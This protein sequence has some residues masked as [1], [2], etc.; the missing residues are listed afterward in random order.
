M[1]EHKFQWQGEEVTLIYSIEYNSHGRQLVIEDVTARSLEIVNSV[2]D[3]IVEREACEA[4][5]LQVAHYS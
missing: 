1:F 3:W 5:T 2:P 4:A